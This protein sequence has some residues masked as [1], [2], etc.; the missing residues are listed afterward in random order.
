MF[1]SSYLCLHGRVRY[2]NGFERGVNVLPW[3]SCIWSCRLRIVVHIMQW[4]D[5]VLSVRNCVLRVMKCHT[6]FVKLN[7]RKDFS[8]F[9]NCP[10]F[11]HVF[12]L[13]KIRVKVAYHSSTKIWSPSHSDQVTFWSIWSVKEVVKYFGWWSEIENVLWSIWN[14]SLIL[15]NNFK[16]LTKMICFRCDKTGMLCH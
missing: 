1:T 15:F 3:V 8:K 10:K 12:V 13:C 7:L 2:A 4:S 5:I 11:V 16:I 6:I 14:C 9:Q